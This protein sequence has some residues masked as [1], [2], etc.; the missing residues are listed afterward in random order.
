[1]QVSSAHS[2][3]TDR[4]NIIMVT[5]ICFL[6]LIAVDLTHRF[7]FQLLSGVVC[8]YESPGVLVVEACLA[9]CTFT[10]PCC[11]SVVCNIPSHRQM[12]GYCSHVIFCVCLPVCRNGMWQHHC[13]AERVYCWR[14]QHGKVDKCN[15]W[16]IFHP[17]CWLIV[18]N[19]GYI[20]VCFQPRS[21]FGSVELDGLNPG[22]VHYVNIMVV[23]NPNGPFVWALV[24]CLLIGL[25]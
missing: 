20:F 6:S 23:T 15:I 10:H 4:L 7:W 11:L 3:F 16:K 19:N 1:M 18:Y 21:M 14:L 5:T 9:K 12:A 2:P 8:L 13:A 17:W 25:N 22:R 24:I